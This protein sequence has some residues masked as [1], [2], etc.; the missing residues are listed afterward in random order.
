MIP[1]FDGH[2]DA[3]HPRGRGRLR[4]GPRRRPPRPARA[5]ARAA[6]RAGSSPCSRRRPG[7][8]RID[9]DRARAGWRSS[10]PRRSAR[11]IAAATTTQAAGRLLGLE[12]DGHLRDRPRD[13][14]TSTP[15]ARTASLAAVMHHEGAEAID[16]GL[17]ALELWYAA[18]LRSLGPVW[19]RPNA[20]AHGVPFAFPAVARHRPGPDDG[21]AAGSC[22]AARELGI[23]VDLSH[24]NEA[25][26]LGRRAARRGAADRL[27]LRR[28]RAVRLDAQP[29]RRPAR[30][31]RRLRR[32][33]RHRLRRAVPA[34]RRRRRRRHAARDDRRARPLR[35]RPHRRRARRARLGLRRRDDPDELGDVAGLPRLVDAL[36]ADGFTEDEVRAI[37]WDN[38]RRVLARAWR[39]VTRRT[40]RRRAHRPDRHRRAVRRPPAGHGA[41]ALRRAAR[42]RRPRRRRRRTRC[43]RTSCSLLMIVLNLLFW[44]PIPARRAVGRLAGPVP[45]RQ[46]ELGNPARLL[47]HARW[48]C[49][50]AWRVLKRLDRA[51]ILVR[52][53]AGID[54]RER[55]P[56]PRV[57]HHRG[58]SARS[59]SPLW[60]LLVGGLGPTL[61]PR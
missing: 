30:R 20:F 45:D 41:D 3:H 33:R 39:R 40:L 34:R 37:A 16:P 50:A 60:L 55:R 22:A 28:A 51:W 19:S 27:A 12:R 14:A 49:S 61:A 6:S 1:V 25:G 13:R 5:P 7:A 2:N 48:C 23:A 46:R 54:Q 42:A 43:S 24:L 56:R 29:H 53:A 47:L 58:R 52:R 18:G 26:L 4:D 36:R 32:A 38:W 8:E 21:R 44:G 31:D 15:P 35:R 10:S 59:A 9:F 57:R 11:E 17:E